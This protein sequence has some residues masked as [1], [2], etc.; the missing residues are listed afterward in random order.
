MSKEQDE[1]C[2]V[3][4]LGYYIEINERDERLLRDLEKN[5][6][7]VAAKTDLR[8]QDNIDNLFVVK[9]G[10]LYSYVDLDETSRQVLRIHYPG[11]VVGLT[12][13][14]MQESF[15]TVKAA[16]KAVLCPFPKK[17]LDEIF[18]QSP[19][20]TALIF[21]LGMLEQ[22]VLMDR[23]KII[24]RMSAVDRVAHFLLEIHARLKI[25]SQTTVHGEFDMPLT[26]EAIGDAIGLT[27]VSVSNALAQ[28]E[29]E[30]YLCCNKRRVIFHEM[31]KLKAKINFKDRYFKIDT[32]WFPDA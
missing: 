22:V 27:N 31:D 14:A 28:L 32:R 30:G 16:T 18:T 17:H 26:Q 11:D 2:L 21:S 4:R 19:R 1:S 29:V 20:L 5:R 23:L 13:V 10:W 7:S 3:C 25:H 9:S 6:I 15:G 12:D 8:A 24:G